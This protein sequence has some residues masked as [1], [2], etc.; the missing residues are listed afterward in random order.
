MLI[1]SNKQKPL[2]IVLVQVHWLPP[3]T[4]KWTTLPICWCA[5]EWLLAGLFLWPYFK[6]FW[7]T[8]PYD[9][10][11]DQWISRSWTGQTGFSGSPP[12]FLESLMETSSGCSGGTFSESPHLFGTFKELLL[13]LRGGWNILYGSL[14]AKP[15][16]D[17]QCRLSERD[18]AMSR[19]ITRTWANF[20]KLVCL[21]FYKYE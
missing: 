8:A 5:L 4:F 20:V 1:T 13:L 9:E 12:L 15:K 6:Q 2:L 11:I 17:H 18:Q 21:H 16:S 3:C 10:F 19:L 14:T 7:L